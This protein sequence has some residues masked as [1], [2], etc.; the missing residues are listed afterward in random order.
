VTKIDSL[1]SVFSNVSISRLQFSRD[2]I[3]GFSIDDR[4]TRVLSLM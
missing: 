3:D 1:C 2:M 4:S